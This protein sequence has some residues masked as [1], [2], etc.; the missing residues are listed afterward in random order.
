[1]K[2]GLRAPRTC[3]GLNGSSVGTRQTW[4]SKLAVGKDQ[5]GFVAVLAVQ[6][7]DDAL[8]ELIADLN[9]GARRGVD[10]GRTLVGRNGT[11]DLA[12]LLNLAAACRR[13][14]RSRCGRCLGVRARRSLSRSDRQARGSG[15]PHIARGGRAEGCESRG[16]ARP[17]RASSRSEQAFG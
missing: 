15:R 3:R 2:K 8:A 13:R 17:R 11:V 5:G 1:M 4:R 9:R 16:K 12:R 10:I 6:P 7:G 14:R